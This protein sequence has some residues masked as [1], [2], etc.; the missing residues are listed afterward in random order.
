MLELI[1][2]LEKSGK[3]L[4]FTL[5]ALVICAGITAW[6]GGFATREIIV[7]IAQDAQ[8]ETEKRLRSEHQAEIKDIRTTIELRKESRDKEIDGVRRETATA[9]KNLAEQVGGLKGEVKDLREAIMDRLP[10][11]PLKKVSL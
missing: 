8:E 1:E 10:P 11:K 6:G 7:K 3:K 9:V 4:G 5:I 2:R